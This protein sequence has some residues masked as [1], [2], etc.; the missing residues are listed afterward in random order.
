[1]IGS[2][3]PVHHH[4][5]VHRAVSW[6]PPPARVDA[7]ALPDEFWELF[8]TGTIFQKHRPSPRAHFDGFF[9]TQTTAT[10]HTFRQ[11]RIDLLSIFDL[12]AHPKTLASVG[13][14]VMDSVLV[15]PNQNPLN[16]RKS[17][18]RN[19]TRANAACR[20]LLAGKPITAM[21]RC[22]EITAKSE[23]FENKSTNK[24]YC[25]RLCVSCFSVLPSIPT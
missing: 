14:P 9:S 12:V 6:Q 3:R 17:T 7:A 8:G 2:E 10:A 24:N 11:Q 21:L 13:R 19:T 5:H 22:V 4:R 16:A 20:L 18:H 15:A 25:C 1:M 23:L